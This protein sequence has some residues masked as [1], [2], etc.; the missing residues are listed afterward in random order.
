[1]AKTREAGDVGFAGGEGEH[2]VAV[3]RQEQ[4]RGR[5]LFVGEVFAQ[6]VKAGKG[7]FR[8]GPRWSGTEMTP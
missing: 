6:V 5:D 1:L 2:A 7:A 4:R 3:A 8:P